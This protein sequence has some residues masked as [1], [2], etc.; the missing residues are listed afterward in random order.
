MPPL[1]IGRR[2]LVVEDL[3]LVSM[4]VE[5]DLRS[6]GAEVIGPVTSVAEALRLLTA[7]PAGG[8][9]D[10]VVLDL[11]LRDGF[12]RPVAERL[13]SRGIPF[14]I[15]T[16]YASPGEEGVFSKAPCLVKPYPPG[17]L[18]MALADLFGTAAQR[19]SRRPRARMGRVVQGPP[20]HSGRSCHFHIVTPSSPG[21]TH[22]RRR[23][24]HRRRAPRARARSVWLANQ[25]PR[26]AAK[27]RRFTMA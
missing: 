6:A 7:L 12:A 26:P 2:I 4:L 22:R 20:D 14:V 19:G 21:A 15:T 27:M 9:V 8:R 11:Q 16:G 18:L 17:D 24:P 23:P 13:V 25:V 5:D 1:L 10:A 3:A